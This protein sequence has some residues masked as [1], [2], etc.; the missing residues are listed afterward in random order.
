MERNEIQLTVKL[1]S[2]Q[3]NNDNILAITTSELRLPPERPIIGMK[4]YKAPIVK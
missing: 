1:N 2:K 3:N 4:R